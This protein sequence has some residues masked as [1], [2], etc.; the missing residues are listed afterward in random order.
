MMKKSN[1]INNSTLRV[2][3]CGII[4]ALSTA[5]MMMTSVIPIGVYALPCFAGMIISIAVV[6]FGCKWAFGV[7]A[8]TAVLSLILA[9]DKEAGITFVL[10]FGYYPI[11]KNIFEKN[12]KHKAL[13]LFLKFLVFNLAAV[14]IFYITTFILAVPAEE[15]TIM[16]VYVP[17]LFLIIG[18]IIFIAYDMAI[19][20][21]VITYVRRLRDKIFG[22][23]K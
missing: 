8:V 3:V 20:T 7:Y 13:R 4:S 17:W 5:I 21:I 6:E 18:N 14:A 10:F 9:G 16:G 22:K 1:G 2:A 23:F 15:Y 11:F 19:T 12:I